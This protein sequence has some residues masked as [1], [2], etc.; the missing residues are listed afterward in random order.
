MD[1]LL[2]VL[3]TGLGAGAIY[4]IIGMGFSVVFKTTRVVNFAHG[5]YLVVAGVLASVLQRN[6]GWP[7]IPTIVIVILVGSAVG[8]GTEVVA[9]RLLNRPD[10]IT[11]TIGTI[12]VGI[13][14]QAIMLKTTNGET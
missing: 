8:V 10:P 5:E 7:L 13:V 14:I 11:V 6:Q 12:A 2:Q 4:A 3:V 9:V 1:T